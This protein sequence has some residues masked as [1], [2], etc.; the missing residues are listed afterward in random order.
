MVSHPVD[1]D[2]LR[3]AQADAAAA[4]GERHTATERMHQSS[5]NLARV[6][7]MAAEA[8]T[9]M[10]RAPSRSVLIVDDEPDLLMLLTEI[11]RMVRPPVTIHTASTAREARARMA[12]HV[13]GVVLLDVMLPDGNGWE[14]AEETPRRTGVIIFSAS[15]GAMLGD[16]G[17]RARADLTLA[18]PLDAAV[19]VKAVEKLLPAPVAE[20]AR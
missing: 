9:Y 16:V 4:H 20:A 2:D 8:A 11:L 6:A 17:R 10:R 15:V 12:A 1:A 13:Y 3:L 19:I 14:L 18:K 7:R 5:R